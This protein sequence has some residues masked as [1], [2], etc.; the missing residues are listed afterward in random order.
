[1]RA[2]VNP[3]VNNYKG[4]IYL[5]GDEYTNGSHRL[6]FNST[7]DLIEVQQRSDNIWSFGGFRAVEDS[8]YLGDTLSFGVSSKFVHYNSLLETDNSILLRAPYDNAGTE[9]P[10]SPDI[11]PLLIKTIYQPDDSAQWSGTKLSFNFFLIVTRVIKKL[12]FEVGTIAGSDTVTF[13]YYSGLVEDADYLLYQKELPASLFTTPS[14]EISFDTGEVLGFEASGFGLMVLESDAT[15]SLTME[16]TGEIPWFAVDEFE[17]TDKLVNTNN[18]PVSV[19]LDGRVSVTA[20]S[21]AVTGDG[22]SF[23]TQIKDGDAIMIADEIFTVNGTPASDT[24]LTLDSNHV[25]GASDVIAYKDPDLLDIQNGD[26]TS[27]FIVD[28]S[29]NLIS[30]GGQVYCLGPSTF[31]SWSTTYNAIQVGGTC[32]LI[33]TTAETLG[34]TAL[35]SNAYTDGPWRYAADGAAALYQI[36][37]A[38]SFFTAAS[39]TAGN[40]VTWGTAA[41]EIGNT[42]N[43]GVGITAVSRLHLY[44][45]NSST[46]ATIGLTIEQDGDGDSVLQFL[47]TSGQRWVMGIDNSDSDKFKIAGTT[48]LDTTEVLEFSTAGQLTLKTSYYA[49]FTTAT[50]ANLVVE[51]S[52]GIVNRSTSSRKVKDNINYNEISPS[53]ALQLKPVSFQSI[54]NGNKSFIGFIAEDCREIDSRLATESSLPGLDLNAIVASLTSLV[55]HQQKEI[56]ALKERFPPGL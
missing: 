54:V 8:F 6:Q 7:D 13:S 45:D 21:A 47:L 56:E 11:G 35:I 29:G 33:G 43:V 31:E 10:R 51:D 34:L 27:K 32:S 24:A 30:S 55:Q 53:L 40:A 20:S 46:G 39:G 3:L 4:D 42:G 15:F 18:L 52:T 36:N 16:T 2:R 12:Y 50:A 26:S 17:Y 48:D 1:M 49:D 37:T 5:Y 14:T 19:Y 22:T 44:E 25:A 41:L 28:K 9:Y 23:L 38:H